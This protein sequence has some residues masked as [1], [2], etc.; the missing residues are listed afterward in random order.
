MTDALKAKLTE[1]H[2]EEIADHDKYKALYDMAEKEGIDCAGMLC[3]IAHE[4]HTHAEA[5][6][7]ILKNN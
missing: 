3:D 7:H 1:A 5:L 6:E 4:E 2:K